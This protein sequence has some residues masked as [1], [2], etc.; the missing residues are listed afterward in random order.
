MD[1]TDLEKAEEQLEKTLDGISRE[2][3]DQTYSKMLEV[4]YEQMLSDY[5]KFLYGV[6]VGIL[7]GFL[8]GLILKSVDL[9]EPSTDTWLI[10]IIFVISTLIINIWI[11]FSGCFKK[12]VIGRSMKNEKQK[13]EIV[14]AVRKKMKKITDEAVTKASAILESE[15][16]KLKNRNT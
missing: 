15:I 14:G 16:E 10:I 8:A 2:F 6:F 3:V 7:G 5:R 13:E 12:Y 11:P 4:G 1:A 9:L